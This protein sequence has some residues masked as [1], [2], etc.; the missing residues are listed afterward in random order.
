MPQ[1]R[2]T[3][4]GGPALRK[5]FQSLTEPLENLEIQKIRGICGSVEGA[6]PIERIEPRKRYKIAGLV[7]NMRIEPRNGTAT[8]TI[9]LNDGTGLARARW[10]GRPRIPGIDVGRYVSIEG[11]AAPD[12]DGGY[13]FLNPYYELVPAD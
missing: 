13:V 2:R 11:T 7:E 9:T 8:L 10:L 6:V 4:E 12:A 1:V 3:P 5:F